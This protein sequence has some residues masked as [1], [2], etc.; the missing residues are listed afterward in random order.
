MFF[1]GINKKTRFFRVYTRLRS[2]AA[3]HSTA[4]RTRFPRA[5]TFF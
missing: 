5:D 4:Q 1:L 3:L 2:S